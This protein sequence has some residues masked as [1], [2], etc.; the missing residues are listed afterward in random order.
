ML[1]DKFKP[2]KFKLALSLAQLS[3]SLFIVQTSSNSV[4]VAL[5][6]L[7]SYPDKLRFYSFLSRWARPAEY[8]INRIVIRLS[9]ATAPLVETLNKPNQLR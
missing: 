9:N 3:P 4:V 6:Q 1:K 2:D 7:V 5:L 8:Y